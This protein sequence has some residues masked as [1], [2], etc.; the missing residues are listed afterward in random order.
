MREEVIEYL[1][2]RPD[3]T[4][5]DATTGLGGHSEAIVRLL[6]AGRLIA[7]DRDGESLERARTRLEPWSERIVFRH[8]KFSELP[9]ALEQLGIGKAD[10]L[11]ADLGVSY[12]QLT[13]PERGFSFA[14]EGPLDMR[15]D[16]TQE[17]TAEDFVN[18]IAEKDLADLLFQFGEERRA[19]RL[20]R[21]VVQARPIRSTRHLADV[22]RSAAPPTKS[23]L[24][25]ATRS[26][27]ALRIA[28][29]QELEELDALLEVLPQV[30]SSGGRAVFLTFHS[31]ED[32]KVKR[33]FQS[34]ARDG[35]AKVLTK[36]VVK[37]SDTETRENPRSRSA[38]LRA[39]EM[40]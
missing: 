1:A 12:E 40:V 18:R 19:R 3:G 24:H 22:I 39:L 26:F 5:V 27:M 4:Y 20:A 8:G 16:R 15:L 34:L 36:H 28:V 31:L 13:R 10:G 30:V 38:K 32:R 23:R 6:G 7:N 29:N 11:I 33:R 9:A 2:P 17:T 37:P 25:P 14:G 21:A 35:R